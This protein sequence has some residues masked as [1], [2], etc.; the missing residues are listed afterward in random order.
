MSS[1]PSSV[2][3]YNR[4]QQVFCL[5]WL[6][7]VAASKIGT[8]AQLTQFA[9]S[10]V[11]QV[12]ANSTVQ[13]LIGTWTP[14]WGPLVTE[15][16]S[17]P[18]TQ[19][20][21]N[22]MFVA[23]QPGENGGT[24]YVVAIAGTN[25]VSVYGWVGEDF[26]VVNTLPW[27]QALADTFT[28]GGINSDTTLPLISQGTA[29]GLNA[30]LKVMTDTAHGGSLM[31]FLTQAVESAPSGPLE[32]IVTGH[33]LGGALSASLA[34]YLADL[35]GVS[36]GWDPNYR[37][38]VSS[39]PSAGAP[40]GNDVFAAHYDAVLGPRTNRVWNALDVIPH[41]WETDLL[42]QA[43]HLYFPYI[44]PNAAVRALVAVVLANT[45][46]S[47][48]T[49]L[50]LNRQTAPLAGQ[51]DIAATTASVSPQQIA[52]DELASLIAGQIAQHYGW[53]DADKQVIQ[54]LI[55]AIIAAVEQLGA[56]AGGGN[57]ASE[58]ALTNDAAS[59]ASAIVKWLEAEFQDIESDVKT[60][61]AAIVK[62]IA[63]A[64]GTTAAAIVAVLKPLFQEAKVAFSWL[65]QAIQAEL[66]NIVTFLTALLGR[67]LTVL[68]AI[69]D[70]LGVALTEVLTLVPGILTFL[71]QLGTQHVT[72]YPQ[73]LGV[74]DFAAQQKAIRSNIVFPSS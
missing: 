69:A 68:Q 15:P 33:S 44:A 14:V 42:V 66:G 65:A 49:Y 61:L 11:T 7:N 13:G 2:P 62:W 74:T 1:Y 54:R 73:L 37:A 39:L 26:D 56:A 38:I 50:Q 8:A 53:P 48:Q 41:A 25:P 31:A 58:P 46:R 17:G 6:A 47:Q 20:A 32:I 10:T 9:N 60:K 72:A 21:G 5:N 63:N 40:P 27:S 3:S 19:V 30:L 22:T 67:V 34:L 43:P 28:G 45:A 23:Q 52:I 55:E 12:L 59:D 71:A 4:L 70:E 16:T 57:Q 24:T 18:F 64:L 29:N 35:Q 36:G 51:V